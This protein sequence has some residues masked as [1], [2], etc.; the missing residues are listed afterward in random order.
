M[1]QNE[2]LEMEQRRQHRAEL[3]ARAERKRRAELAEKQRESM[4]RL[5]ANMTPEQEIERQR[6]A[7]VARLRSVLRR[8]VAER[9]DLWKRLNAA[10]AERGR[11]ERMV[12]ELSEELE[13]ERARA[14][15]LRDQLIEHARKLREKS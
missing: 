5:R 13:D 9:D 8:T 14:D 11:L 4:L 7:N 6:L 10:D 12:A 15:R 1:T 3:R 2:R